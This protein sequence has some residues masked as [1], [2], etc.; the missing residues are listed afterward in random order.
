MECR[1]H[2]GRLIW[3]VVA[4]AVGTCDTPTGN[5]LSSHL[6]LIVYLV[7]SLIIKSQ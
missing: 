4:L 6:K 7:F 3:L 2:G 1:H 5:V